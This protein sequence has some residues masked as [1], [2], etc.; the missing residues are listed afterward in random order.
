MVTAPTGD[1]D[2]LRNKFNRELR[3]RDYYPNLPFPGDVYVFEN[4]LG[5]DPNTIPVNQAITPKGYKA[6]VLDDSGKRTTHNGEIVIVTRK[7][8]SEQRKLLKQWWPLISERLR[9]FNDDWY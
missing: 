7:F 3:E 9:G 1:L 4:V 6:F 5:I 2:T 8:T